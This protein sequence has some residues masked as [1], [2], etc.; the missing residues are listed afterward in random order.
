[1]PSVDLLRM[2][3]NPVELVLEARS[4]RLGGHE[5]RRVLP[6]RRR[7]RIGPF[8]F[9]DHIGPET[10]PPGRGI[11]V[12]P[13]PHIHLATVTYLFEGD[14]VHRDSLGC[15]ETIRPGEINWMHAGRG[16]VHSERTGPQSRQRQS[17]VHGVQLWVALPVEREETPPAFRHYPADVLPVWTGPGALARILVGEA[18]GHVSAVETSSAT[19]YVDLTLAAGSEVSVPPSPERGVYVVDGRVSIG[20]G[21]FGAGQLV[22][23]EPNVDAGIGA[24]AD[25]RCL[26]LGGE[27]LEGQRH[28]WWNFVSSSV[29]RI[30]KARRDWEDGRFPPVPADDEFVELP[31]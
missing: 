10:L 27:A 15:V 24:R 12:P 23:L 8:I 5:I 29:E 2:R 20:E 21:E 25:A 7:Q 19:L 22:V 18:F 9:L 4:R 31:T 17:G 28:I 1:M 11:D 16:I 6:T 26:I 13:H 30:E 14:L 3:A